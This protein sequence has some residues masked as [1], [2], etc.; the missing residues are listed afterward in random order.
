MH[1][2]VHLKKYEHKFYLG[3]IEIHDKSIISNFL[4]LCFNRIKYIQ[5]RD[6]FENPTD[7]D[8]NYKYYF[9]SYKYQIND[10]NFEFIDD[11]NSSRVLFM[12]N[13]Q[14][15]RNFLGLLNIYYALKGIGKSITLIKT[16]KYNYNH[17]KF[18]ILYI[19]CK[20]LYNY[21]HDNFQ[22]FKKILK[23][24]II[25]LFKNEYDEY[26]NYVKYIDECQ[27]NGNTFFIFII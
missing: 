19:H 22:K 25:Y 23:D 17:D 1:L 27:N 26:K 16:F 15:P 2:I 5:D 9:D 8:I 20:C 18:G 11:E 24:E 14:C 12:A 21:Y 3:R 13:L 4:K 7:F 10:E 6:V